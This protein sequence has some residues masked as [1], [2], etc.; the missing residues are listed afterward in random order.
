MTH[1]WKIALA[2]FCFCGPHVHGIAEAKELTFATGLPPT[3]TW[4]KAYT[5]VE[6]HIEERTGGTL[7]AEVYYGSLLNLK[8]SL[9]CLLYTSDAA[10]E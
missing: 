1:C 5:Y 7:S 3:H 2:L 4:A 9:T 8:Q 10:D 6:Q